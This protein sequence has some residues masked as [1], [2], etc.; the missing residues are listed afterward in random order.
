MMNLNEIG[1]KTG[2]CYHTSGIWQFAGYAVMVLKIVIP[3][4]LIILGI[5]ALG[6]AVIAADDK[7]IK[8]AV[9]SL[10]KKFIAAVIIFF[11]PAIVSA[12]FGVVAQ[13]NDV[14]ADYE[15]CVECITRPTK[16]ECKTAV[17]ATT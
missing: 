6:K 5:V 11:I 9:N 3:A 4:I 14:K 13:F 10:I 1:N 17:N 2:F 7:E 12:L 15:V 16:N 8:T